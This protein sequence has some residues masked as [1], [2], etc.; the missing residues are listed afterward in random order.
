MQIKLKFWQI[1]TK[2]G[3]D[4]TDIK[5][6]AYIRLNIV[7]CLSSFGAALYQIQIGTKIFIQIVEGHKRKAIIEHIGEPH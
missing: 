1:P 4:F 2:K 7:D 6:K 3:I 5:F